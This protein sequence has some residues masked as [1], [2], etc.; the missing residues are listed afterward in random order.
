MKKIIMMLL[1]VLL[2]ATGCSSTSSTTSAETKTGKANGF[3]GLVEVT[4]TVEGDKITG[5]DV[6]ADGETPDI[7]GA[8]IETLTA[9][10]LE[11][12]S[13]DVEM[14]SGATVTSTALIN[15]INNALD[16]E[17]YPFE[18]PAQP[19]SAPV[20]EVSAADLTMGTAVFST[21]RLG[22]G[23]DD[24]D[25][26]VYSFNE[27]YAS[28]LFDAE[29][30]IVDMYLDQF[31]VATPNYD[32]DGMPHFTGFPGQSYNYDEDHDAKVDGTQTSD[33]DMFMAEIESWA[34]KR[35][36]GD[37]YSMGTGK[38]YQQADKYEDLFVGMTVEEVEDWFN[39]YCS[40][41]NG[42]PLK[43]GSEA[44]G[45]AEKYAALSD[46]E[47]AMLADVTSS[48]TMSLNDGHGNI[49]GAILKAYEVRKPVN[50]GEIVKFGLGLSNTGRVGP[51]SDDTDTPV[52]S[53]NQV[54]AS[55]LF[56]AEGKIVSLNLDQLEIATPNY[57][58]DG[59]PH[60][61]GF[62]GQSYN[63]DEDHDAKVDGTQTS[64]EDMFMAEIES[65]A[66]KRERGDGYSMGTGKWYQQADK[67]EDLFVG[68][69]VEEV[70]DW[71]NKYCSD[72]NGRPLKEGSE[73]EGDA[74]KYAALSDDEKAMLADVTS[75]A[76]MSLN[77]SHG[78]ILAAIKD[79]YE[80]SKD[81]DIVVE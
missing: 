54:F 7:G 10:I 72:A 27:V 32:G 47:K 46:D 76:T 33:E 38:W 55:G 80:A 62:P 26:P 8:A 37:G 66:T 11:S 16:P 73:A 39:K 42:R 36:R 23:S 17:A 35:E 28:V 53:F 67:Y 59:M 51:G 41:A 71:F 25:T 77:D 3:G 13:V 18:E 70:E 68:M 40:D 12:G 22:P 15:A 50:S 43:E 45:D 20:E 52:Y 56:D 29:G 19:T 21:G 30:K 81:V 65:W 64:D 75:S 34:T 57:D 5:L 79:A 78:N 60:F 63:Y 2:L 14:V 31:E 24:T 58:G 48:A 9:A 61:T 6:S 4:V 74:E 69:T 44:E 49:I 1:A